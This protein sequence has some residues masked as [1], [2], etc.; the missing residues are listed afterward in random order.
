M[1]PT[2]VMVR[3]GLLA[4]VVTAVL[5]AISARLDGPSPVLFVAIRCSLV[6]FAV[7]A[8]IGLARFTNA[9]PS[10]RRAASIGMLG[11]AAQAIGGVIMLTRGAS[12]PAEL[13][14]SVVI[15]TGFGI[16]IGMVATTGVIHTLAVALQR[17]RI[18]NVMSV[19]ISLMLAAIFAIPK[20]ETN[21]ISKATGAA[22]AGV[23]LLVQI[24]GC[25]V[26]ITMIVA[27]LRERAGGELPR[28][29]VVS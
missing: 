25:A 27:S 7:V 29:A 20:L 15:I 19:M 11:F 28:A 8:V 17:R 3:T 18:A 2:L 9:S 6:G 26:A 4:Y 24:V 13:P 14:E 1:V 12:N 10:G 5:T 23:V 21:A 22:I 16:L